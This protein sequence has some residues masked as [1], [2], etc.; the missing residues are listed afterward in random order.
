M[1]SPQPK[2]KKGHAGRSRRAGRRKFPCTS[3]SLWRVWLIE[4]Y[5]VNVL[6][7]VVEAVDPPA[8]LVQSNINNW[9]PCYHIG[10]VH[11]IRLTAAFRFR[12][13][14]IARDSTCF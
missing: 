11:S 1:T 4:G 8:T 10:A 2:G 13:K 9:I 6:E 5:L 3:G 14:P 12:T 7:F